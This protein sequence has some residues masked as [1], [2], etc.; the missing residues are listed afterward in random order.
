MSNLTS[1][2][3]DLLGVKPKK[4]R[5]DPYARLFRAEGIAGFSA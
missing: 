3:H 1:I 2:L 5:A 4:D